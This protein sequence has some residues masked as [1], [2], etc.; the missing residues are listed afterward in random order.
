MGSGKQLSREGSPGEGPN[1]SRRLEM[2]A[3]PPYSGSESRPHSWDKV[4]GGDSDE[5]CD[6]RGWGPVTKSLEGCGE[7][8][9]F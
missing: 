2:W 1:R 3:T 5:R 7:G 4:N 8:F 6:Q 9:R